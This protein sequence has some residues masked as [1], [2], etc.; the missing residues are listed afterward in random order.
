MPDTYNFLTTQ[1]ATIDRELMI[2]Y[3]NTGT[4]AAPVWSPLGARVEDSSAEY[5]WQD[6]NIKDILGVTRGSMKK[7]I[8][9]QTFDPNK[10]DSA[11]AALTNIWQLAIVEQNISAL[12]SMDMLIVHFYAGTS[13]TAFF[14]ERYAACMVKPTGLGGEGGGDLSMPI[15]VTYAGD[16]TIGTA[17]RGQSGIEFTPA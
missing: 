15:D 6:E 9:T 5:D 14:A 4:S 2:A 1:G 8:V 12:A 10:L 16:R 17:A 13:D 7:P 11:Q 3:L